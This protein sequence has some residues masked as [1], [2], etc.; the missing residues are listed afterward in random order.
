MAVILKELKDTAADYW[1]TII[2]NDTDESTVQVDRIDVAGMVG[3][4]DD[5]TDILEL[6]EIEWNVGGVANGHV[7]MFWDATADVPFQMV[8]GSGS[9]AWNQSNNAGTGITGNVNVQTSA[10]GVRYQI[11]LKFRKVSGFTA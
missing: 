8:T 11:N 7:T 2:N 1:V 10:A 9:S 3:A 4:L 5:G 6:T